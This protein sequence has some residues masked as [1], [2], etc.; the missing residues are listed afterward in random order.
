MNDCLLDSSFVID[1]LNEIAGGRDGP[2]LAWLRRNPRAR[3]WISPVT[4]AEALEGAADVD[5]VGVYLARY[6]WQGIHRAHAG[7]VAARQRG[8]ARRM[9]ENDAWQCAIAQRMG[10][11]IVGHDKAFKPLG[12]RYDD[13]RRTG[14]ASLRARH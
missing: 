8:S 2:A 6:A 11:V 9:G 7:W 3:L 1:L 14:A 10:A 5:A 13:H 12:A 4:L